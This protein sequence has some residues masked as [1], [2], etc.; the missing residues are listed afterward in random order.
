MA[1]LKSSH[2]GEADRV[3]RLE[4][5]L[6]ASRLLNS[7]LELAELTEIV[8]RIVRDEV[9]VDRCTLFV[10]DR[11]QMLLRS[12]IAQGVGQFEIAL[13]VGHGL[14]GIVAS[15]GQP[16]DVTDAYQDSRFE[17]TFDDRLGYITRDVFSIP[18]FNREG[19]LV[20]VLQMLNRKRPLTD[21]DKEF[22]SGMCTYLGLAVH[23]AW[24]HRELLEN[25]KLEE[26]LRLVRDR[27]AHQEKLS[28]MGELIGGVI[29]EMR[30]PLS[31]ALGQCTLLRDEIKVSA[32]I[33]SRIA[34][35]E[36]GIDRA[37]KIA[38]NFLNFARGGSGEQT[39]TDVNAIVR[40]TVDLLAYEFRKS[41]VTVELDL[42]SLPPVNVDPGRIQ[43]VLLNLLK[44]AQ[45]SVAER[46]GGTVW[47]RSSRD[48]KKKAIRI[49]VKDDGPGIPAI[50]QPRVFEP[51]FT[52]KPRGSGTG[53]GL[54]VSRRIAEEHR[55]SL[56]FKSSA[57]SGTTFVLVLPDDSEL[58]RT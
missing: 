30:N 20:G 16:L 54:S 1:T 46:R 53:F 47:V 18:V 38:R 8:L 58:V 45:E 24:I 29:H 51:F 35:I 55:G 2:Q 19:V 36:T 43:Q 39:P 44:N 49:Q 50:H 12:F 26:E 9:P 4:R 52:T 17:H 21:R 25:R 23:N 37:A 13:P 6:D 15:T 10:L 40:Q 48:A 34:K 22:L 14:A 42:Q 56:S 11:R 27:L 3:R 32:S 5:L 33:A 57:G 31:V 7:T 28:A 41:A